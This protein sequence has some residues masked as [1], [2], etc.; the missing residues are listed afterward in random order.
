MLLASSAYGQTSASG[1]GS[2]DTTVAAPQAS[3]PATP[4][5]GTV[6]GTTQQAETPAPPPKNDERYRDGMVIWQTPDDDEVPFLLKFNLNTQFRYLNT[7]SSD[8]TFT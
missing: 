2:P 6:P 1:A 4:A 5:A 8:D 7:L 3:Q